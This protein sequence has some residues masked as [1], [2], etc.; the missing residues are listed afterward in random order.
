MKITDVKT[1]RLRASIPTGGQVF[2]R[3]GVRNTRL[4]TLIQVDTDEGI[5]GLG[6]ASGNGE[7]IEFIVARVL[8]PMLIGMDPTQIDEIWDTAY[9]RGGHKEFGTRG[10]GVVA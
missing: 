5:S 9:V 3:S 1:I 6:S 2:S 8:K 7:L 10:V 4:A